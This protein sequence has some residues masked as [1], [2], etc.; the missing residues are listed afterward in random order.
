MKIREAK[1]GEHRCT[2]TQCSYYTGATGECMPC[3]DCGIDPYII[4]DS[5]EK[6]FKCENVP[7][8]LRFSD[9]KTQAL[10]ET[11]KE[12]LVLEA[13]KQAIEQR[14][15]ELDNPTPKPIENEKELVH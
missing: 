5:C 13:T 10:T 1:K 2:Q 14:L 4:N 6:C 11:M 12:K 15:K 8:E 3:E 7:N 9:P